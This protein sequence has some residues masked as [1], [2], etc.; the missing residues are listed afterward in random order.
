MIERLNDYWNRFFDRKLKKVNDI[1]YNAM[2]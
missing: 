1:N 2:I